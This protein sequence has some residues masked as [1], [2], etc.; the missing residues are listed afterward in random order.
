MPDFDLK[1]IK[2]TIQHNNEKYARA[3]LKGDATGFIE[4][5]HSRSISMPPN[6]GVKDSREMGEFIRTIPAKGIK[7]YAL[8][9][10]EVFG[11]PEE[12]IERG[13]YEVGDGV[14]TIDHGKFIA[15]WKQEK[16]R[17]KIYRSI[18]NSD[19]VQ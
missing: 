8:Q 13:T 11:G 1:K 17:W 14:H 15:I 9:A 18:W 4:L 19:S 7:S 3:F 12:V 16:G 2:A 10:L 6:E 5:H